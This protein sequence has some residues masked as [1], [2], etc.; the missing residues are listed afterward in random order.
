MRHEV[1]AGVELEVV[2]DRG[3]GDLAERSADGWNS[4]APLTFCLR[5]ES[6]GSNARVDVGV[7]TITKQARDS[8]RNGCPVRRFNLAGS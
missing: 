4:G 1:A 2:A 3:G 5:A 6:R 7:R 8:E